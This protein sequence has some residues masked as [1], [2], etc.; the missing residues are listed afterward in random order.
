MKPRRKGKGKTPWTTVQPGRLYRVCANYPCQVSVRATEAEKEA[1]DRAARGAGLSQSRYLART[2]ADA[3]YPPTLPDREEL[4][5]VRLL[6][7]KAGVNLNQIAR[8]MNAFARG[9]G[10]TLPALAE[11]SEAGKVVRNLCRAL[12]RCL[13]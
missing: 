1:I 10:K 4:R 5:R 3:R 11:I 13:E 12:D 9:T 2:I 8:Q 7:E 6:L